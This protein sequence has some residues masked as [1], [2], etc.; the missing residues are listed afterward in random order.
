MDMGITFNQT[1]TIINGKEVFIFGGEL[2]YFRVPQSQ[3]EERIIKVKEAGCNLISTYVPWLWHEKE[4]GVIDLVGNTTPERDLETFLK[5]IQK[6]DMYCLFRPGPYVMA[7]TQNSGIPQWVEDHYPQVIAKKQD[8][9]FHPTKVVSYLHPDFLKLTKRWYQAICELVEPFQIQNQGCVIMMQIDNEVGMLQWVTNQADYNEDTITR[10][11]HAMEHKYQSVER[12]NQ[13]L[14]TTIETWDELAACLRTPQKA[15]AKSLQYEYGLFMR[16]YYREFIETLIGYAKQSKIDLPWVV[17]VHGFDNADYAKRGRM[18]PIG[19]SQL[20]ETANIE[21]VVIAGDYY[22]GNITPDNFMD[23]IIANA[24]TKAMQPAAQ[25]LFSAEFQGGFQHGKP[26]LQPSTIDLTTRT[27]LANGM[28]A[29][30]Y[31]MFVG[32]ENYENIGLLGRRH[33]W[34]A[35]ISMSGEK[36]PSYFKIQHLSKVI[37]ALEHEFLNAQRVISTHIGFYADYYMS[38]YSNENT[39]EMNHELKTI[40]ENY[41]FDGIGKG[42]ALNN[43]TFEGIDIMK[44]E[45]I[46][47]LKVPSLW[48]QTTKWMNADVQQRLVDYAEAGGKLLLYPTIPVLDFYQKPCTILKDYLAV[49]QYAVPFC[50]FGTI[51]GVDSTLGIFTQGFYGTFESLGFIENATNDICAFEKETNNQG[52]IIVLGF[53]ME[54]EFD[55]KNEIIRKLAQRMHVQSAGCENEV[56]DL[57]YQQYEDTKLMFVQNY[58]DE[59]KSLALY[60]QNQQPLHHPVVVDGK[61]GL[62]L[63]MDLPLSFVVVQST[64]MELVERCF[65]SATFLAKQR[66]EYLQLSNEVALCS[67][68]GTIEMVKNEQG[69]LYI[70][71]DVT[72]LT[73]QMK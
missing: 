32:G 55:Y 13:Q 21:N 5:L 67:S 37:H 8:G 43:M 68:S 66:I 34:Q 35:P 59:A 18:Y 16:N 63:V 53:G 9:S 42:L 39:W 1:K 27:C 30:N 24:Y 15:F 41:F 71:K 44:A 62:L 50:N 38:E 52:K 28:H 48:I 69:V 60:T 40:R 56:V 64:S 49:E 36:R 2:H 33:D 3:W 54:H 12:L 45:A 11:I 10:F 46:D 29:L 6:H 47:V 20:Y 65:E 61:S 26:R 70:C 72:E 4:E 57:S 73:I 25:P 17:N 31:Y 23:L 51:D 19:L 22:I 14:D 58:E 7:E